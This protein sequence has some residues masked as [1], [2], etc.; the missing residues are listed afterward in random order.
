MPDLPPF[1]GYARIQYR[2][3]DGTR[4]RLLQCLNSRE[5]RTGTEIG[6]QLGL[7]RAAVHKQV[8]TLVEQG[9]PIHRVPGRGYRL[10]DG[11]ALLDAHAIAR[12]L[13]GRAQALVCGIDVLD[14]VDSTS[15]ELDRRSA[16]RAFNGRVCLAEKQVSGRGRRGRSWIASPYRD[17]M[18]SIGIEYPQWPAQLP[19]LGL[20]TAL[21]VVD[22][23]ASLGVPGLMVKWPNDVVHED[24]KVCGVLLDVTGETHG[25]CRV[26]AGIGINVSSGG[27]EARDIGRPWTDLAAITG[28][29]PDRNA[30][31]VQCLDRLL[32]A[33][34]EFP[35]AGFGPY[36]SAWR[37]LDALRGRDI[38]VHG[39]DGA[40]C[41]G[42]AGGV[43]E[44]GRLRMIDANG[45]GRVFTQ[46]D[47]S[48]R[49]R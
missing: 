39:V 24:G 16:A 20:V 17:I 36:R 31:V 7:S 44:S 40:T 10:A 9:V 5:F 34:R 41:E 19:T 43:D 42:K 27:G 23:L 12:R 30:V 28:P 48:V 46:G 26:I 2:A 4:H 13:S 37:R 22:A 32:P 15:A 35:Q 25:T 1:A 11:I 45:C 47:V 33:F 3:M 18:M 38:V 8:G 29:A 6:A 14:E 49:V 21:A